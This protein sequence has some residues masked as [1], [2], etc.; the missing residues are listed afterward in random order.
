MICFLRVPQKFWPRFMG[1]KPAVLVTRPA[2]QAAGLCASLEA[3]GYHPL[4]QPMLELVPLDS[5]QE[6]QQCI[7]DLNQ[8]QHIIFVSGNAVDFALPWIR[9]SWPTL[10]EGPNWYAIGGATRQRLLKSGVSTVESA[11]GMSTESLLELTAL[12]DVSGERVLIVKGEGGRTRM[13]E[14]LS[15][16]GA[17]VEELCC[18]RR[19]APAMG[20][21]ELWSNLA[22]LQPG[23]I[24]ISSGEG[25][26]NMLTLIS[27][28]E[29]R[30]LLAVPL[31][32]PSARVARQA[33]GSGF[34]TVLT[35]ANASDAAMLQAVDDWWANKPSTGG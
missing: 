8:Y 26:A 20:E 10:P 21:G 22:R 14:E 25:L 27:P 28:Q 30:K 33:Q 3:R 1:A 11:A 6:Q 34:S 16:R 4:S 12:K 17:A 32:T 13:L 31:V 19:Q 9:A 35:A 15:T 24:L 18:Y 5:L 29:S 23:L 2:G 7:V